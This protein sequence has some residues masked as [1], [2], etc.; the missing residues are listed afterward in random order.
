[1]INNETITISSAL[2]V[3]I[4]C[5]PE[6]KEEGLATWAGSVI[7]GDKVRRFCERDK[8]QVLA[9]AGGDR[10][11]LLA[12]LISAVQDGDKRRIEECQKQLSAT[13]DRE[14]ETVGPRNVSR[15]QNQYRQWLRVMEYLGVKPDRGRW[16]GKRDRLRKLYNFFGGEFFRFFGLPKLI[17]SPPPVGKR[18]SEQRKQRKE[19]DR[20]FKQ[21]VRSQE[22]QFE[23]ILA[24]DRLAPSLAKDLNLSSWQISKLLSGV[25]L[26]CWYSK[27][28][29]R[30][31]LYCGSDLNA[32][33]YASIFTQGLVMVGAARTLCLLCGRSFPKAGKQK[34]CCR[35]HQTTDAQRR[36]RNKVVNKKNR[37]NR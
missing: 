31:A 9:K 14:N 23:E 30:P 35:A 13:I 20:N 34:Y 21:L 6:S 29:F 25:R 15:D 5:E 27:R 36:Y 22:K 19:Y 26:V 18:G 28:R 7:D 33:Y 12:S 10:L 37:F 24:G 16:Y 1:M 3:L 4:D 2:P 32:A 8:Q 11:F 17:Y